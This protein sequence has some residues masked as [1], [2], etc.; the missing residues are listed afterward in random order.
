MVNAPLSGFTSDRL[1]PWLALLTATI[2]FNLD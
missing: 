2:L 1:L